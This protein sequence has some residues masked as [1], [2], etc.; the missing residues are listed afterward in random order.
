MQFNI[1]QKYIAGFI[2]LL[3]WI[4]ML[5]IA[6]TFSGT[7][8]EGD[9]I[10]HYLYARAALKQPIYFFDHWAKPV[11][12]LITCLPAQFG[13]K[14]IQIFNITIQAISIFITFRIAQ[15]LHIK[16]AWLVALFLAIF[17]HQIIYALSGLTEPLFALTLM[18]ILFLWLNQKQTIALLILS[19]LPFIRSE[20]LIVIVVFCIYL[21]IKKEQRRIPLLFVGHL[22]YTILGVLLYNKSIGWTLI[23]NPYAVGTT[24]Y[25]KGPWDAFIVNMRYAVGIILY[26][27]TGM[28]LLAGLAYSILKFI[29]KKDVNFSLEFL[30]LIYGI[31]FS[32]FFFHSFAWYKGWFHSFGLIRVMVGI[33]PLIALICAKF[34]NEIFQYLPNRKTTK[35]GFLVVVL[36]LVFFNFYKKKYAIPNKEVLSLNEDQQ[37]QNEMAAYLNRHHSEYKTMP[38][39]FAAPYISVALDMDYFDRKKHPDLNV[40]YPNQLQKPAYL[41]WDD[42]YAPVENHVYLD[43]LSSRKDIKKIKSFSKKE[44]GYDKIRTTILFKIE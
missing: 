24:D 40:D 20:G 12:V 6:N 42:W 34:L 11:Y 31:A 35:I 27:V 13:F 44:N 9:S 17:P 8:D 1:A 41:I 16:Q 33:L 23:E 21:L 3:F 19:F 7:G 4:T 29:L 32:I 36:L 30:F 10:M 2:A 18:T 26:Y 22:I 14:G 25:G 28:G 43:D 38:I 5:V 37:I 39:Y 15:L